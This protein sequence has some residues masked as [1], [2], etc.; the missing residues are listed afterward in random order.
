MAAQ[1]GIPK[2]P[3]LPHDRCGRVMP[4]CTCGHAVNEVVWEILLERSRNTRL[5]NGFEAPPWPSNWLFPSTSG[6]AAGLGDNGM[7]CRATTAPMV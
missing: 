4:D 2:A 7:F 5:A 6:Y 3:W 1:A